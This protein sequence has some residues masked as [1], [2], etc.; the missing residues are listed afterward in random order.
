M[1]N[2]QDIAESEAP[3][4]SILLTFDFDALCIWLTDR[5]SVV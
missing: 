1:N 4:L 5:K 3:G 2:S